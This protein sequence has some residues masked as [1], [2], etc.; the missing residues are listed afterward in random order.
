VFWQAA[1]EGRRFLTSSC[2]LNKQTT[3]Q[4]KCPYILVARSEACIQLPQDSETADSCERGREFLTQQRAVLHNAI[5][6]VTLKQC[7]SDRK[8]PPPRRPQW[9]L[10]GDTENN[11]SLYLSNYKRVTHQITDMEHNINTTSLI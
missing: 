1:G 8:L 3:T 5:K 2:H 10:P 7:P 9:S 11:V 4:S 6:C